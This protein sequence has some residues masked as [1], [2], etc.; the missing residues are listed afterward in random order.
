MRKVL[1]GRIVAMLGL[2]VHCLKTNIPKGQKILVSNHR[3]WIDVLVIMSE[4]SCTAV[5]KVE[6][7]KTPIIGEYLD[8]TGGLFIKRENNRS[9]YLA[10][11][12]MEKAIK[13][14]HTLLIFPEGTTHF[15]ETTMEFGKGIFHL[16][17]KHSIPIVPIAIE[18]DQ[19]SL[20]W[21]DRDTF[22]SNFLRNFRRTGINIYI[23]YGTPLFGDDRKELLAVTQSQINLKLQ[24]FKRQL[25]EANDNQPVS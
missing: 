3:S 1:F 15:K 22:V 4:Y 7:K 14:G 18:Y 9:R 11:L 12:Q 23:D 6:V 19:K 10:L 17:A 20:E 16:A 21:R 2:N 8:R 24:E 5:G 25:E 13:E